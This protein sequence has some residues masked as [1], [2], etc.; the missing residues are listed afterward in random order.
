M[1]HDSWSERIV[2]SVSK[3]V[4]RR[5]SRRSFIARTTMLG[6]AVAVSGT[7][8]LTRPVTS[9]AAILACPGGS[10]CLDGYTEFC[11]VINGGRNTCPAGSVPSGWWRADFSY[12][13][14]GQARYYIDCNTFG[15]AACG[16]ANGDCNHR[17]VYCNR[18]R[19]GQCHQEIPGTG[20]IACRMVLCEPPY[21]KPE[22]GCS[23][24]GAVDNSTAHHFTSC[25]LPPSG[26]PP[27]LNPPP[28]AVLPLGASGVAFGAF[29]SVFG[30]GGDGAVWYRDFNGKAWTPWRSLGQHTT[31]SIYAV[32]RG[33]NTVVVTRNGSN[34]IVYRT[35]FGVGGAWS[36][37]G[38]LGGPSRSDPAA[39]VNGSSLWV[40]R[41]SKKHRLYRKVHDGAHW[42]GWSNLDGD[43]RSNPVAASHSTG[44]YVFRLAGDRSLRYRRFAGGWGGWRSL[45]GRLASDP[46]AA[47]HAGS[48]FV[49]GRGTDHAVW[50]RRLTGG[51]W[52][53]WQSLG[54]SITSEPAALSYGGKL[55]LVARMGPNNALFYRV[56]QGAWS[57][58]SPIGGSLTAD[59]GLVAASHGLYLFD[60]GFDR[61]MWYS[62]W[63]GSAWSHFQ[64]LGGSFAPVRGWD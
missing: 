21:T 35:R 10:L 43:L 46:V 56:L 40:F 3:V 29:M 13:C 19:Y 51:S 53:A 48:L 44:L 31:S 57:Q 16:C 58:W 5:V 62:R 49:F 28:A 32:R 64:S 61:A 45:G 30:R 54:G 55:L 12:F 59:A 8:V 1:S 11:C 24:S 6:S 47:N 38:S 14:G 34:D 42:S 4:D 63:N 37:W 18:F 33:A 50:Y 25:L 7:T 20:T 2:R 22:L 52:S 26:P 9:Y 15:P 17:K 27:N 41:R 39:L 60:R 36:G 23:P